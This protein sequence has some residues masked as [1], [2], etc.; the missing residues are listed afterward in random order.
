MPT[1]LSLR[2][3]PSM[4]IIEAIAG[5]HKRSRSNISMQARC[6]TKWPRS[7]VYRVGEHWDAQCSERTASVDYYRGRGS[8]D[9]VYFAGIGGGA[10]D[11]RV[12]LSGA[13]S[14]GAP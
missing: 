13:S 8:S 1:K 12:R 4:P 2:S 11:D 9:A 7:W 6:S 5:Q 14:G 3:T 10:S